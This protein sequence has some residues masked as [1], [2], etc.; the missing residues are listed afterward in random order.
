MTIKWGFEE[1]SKIFKWGFKAYYTLCKRGFGVKS[2]ILL[3]FAR[4]SKDINS[5]FEEIL[6]LV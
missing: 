4:T 5:L 2:Y 6:E 1:Y 3:D